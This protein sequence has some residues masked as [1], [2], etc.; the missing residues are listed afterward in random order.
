MAEALNYTVKAIEALSALD[1]TAAPLSRIGIRYLVEKMRQAQVF[2]LPDAGT[3]LDR[4]KPAPEVPGLTFTPTFPVMALEYAMPQ[5]KSRHTPGYTD[6]PSSRRIALAWRWTN[7][8]PTE[9]SRCAPPITGDG[10]VIA[11]IAYL[12]D[13]KMWMPMATAAHLPFDDE[14][15]APT[16]TPFKAAAL[17][18]GQMTKAQVNARSRA[19]GYVPILPEA[20]FGIISTVGGAAATDHLAADLMDEINAYI[21]LC[22]ALSCRNVE[23]IRHPAAEKLNRARARQGKMPLKDFHVLKLAGTDA[24]GSS[25]GGGGGSASRRAHLRRG[26]IRQLRHLGEGRLTWVNATMVGGKGFIDKA[27]RL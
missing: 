19:Y 26:H 8:L 12:D 10:V 5:D 1:A 24:S 6:A 13:H 4:S 14:W 20:L 23:S 3:L 7:D 9:L 15:M 11:S 27:Y 18:A 17:A 25:A 22:C 2:I 21:D 16:M